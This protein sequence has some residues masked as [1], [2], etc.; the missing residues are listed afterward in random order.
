MALHIGNAAC[1]PGTERQRCVRSSLLQMVYFLNFNMIAAVLKI[2][3][4]SGWYGG[5]Y[6]HTFVADHGCVSSPPT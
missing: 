1:V 2:V 3:S 4:T 6:G 5:W